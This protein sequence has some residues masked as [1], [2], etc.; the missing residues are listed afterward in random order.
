MAHKPTIAEARDWLNIP[1]DGDDPKLRLMIDAAWDEHVKATS[2]V[3]DTISDV[4]KVMLLERVANTYGYRGDDS[5]GPS[6]WFVDTVRR[7]TNPNAI[8]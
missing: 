5:V 6:T 7:L 4:E 8:G 1:H 3:G 2:L